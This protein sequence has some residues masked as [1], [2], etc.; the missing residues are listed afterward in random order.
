MLVVL[1]YIVSVNKMVCWGEGWVKLFL[2]G[3]NLEVRCESYVLLISFGG[4]V[5]KAPIF[6]HSNPER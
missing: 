5:E 4:I 3:L 1:T 6:N 2:D